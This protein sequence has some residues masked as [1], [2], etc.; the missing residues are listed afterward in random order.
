M[1]EVS[2]DIKKCILLGFAIAAPIA[3]LVEPSM[4]LVPR[5]DS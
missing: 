3:V 5:F 1:N 2:P 4:P